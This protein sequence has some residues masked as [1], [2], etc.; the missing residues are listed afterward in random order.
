MVQPA[1]NYTP[2]TP[3]SFL[4]R[5]A[6]VFPEK[7]AVVYKDTRYTYRQLR[8]RVNRCATALQAAGVTPGDRVAFLC[9][10]IPP[11]LEAH[12]SVPLAGGVL[13]PINTRL[14]SSEIAYILHHSGAKVLCVD[15]ELADLIRPMRAQ[16]P[17][18]ETIINVIDGE[19]G[20]GLEGPDYETFLA[21]GTDELL[22]TWGV[23]AVGA[24][25]VCLRRLDP[26][27]VFRLIEDESVS[28][29]C[30]AP[31]V[32]IMLMSHPQ[33]KTAVFPRKLHVTTAGAPPSPTVIANMEALGAEI[34][35]VY[36]LTETYG[37][38]SIC[39]W[40]E[41]W[42]ALPADER[43]RKKA[44][45]GVPYIIAEEMRVVDD[46]MQDV[47]ADAETLGEVIMR[48]NNV[49]RGYYNQ[50]EATA[51]AFR[52][53]WFHSG[54]LAVMHPDGYV[55]LRDRKKDIIISG[56]ENIST[57]EVE[58]TIYRHPAVQEVAVVAIPDERWGEVPK[59]FVVPKPGMQ[60]T[61]ED[62][63][64]FCRQH[65]AHFKCPKAVEFGDLPKTSTGKIKKFELRE[66]EWQ[67]YEKR[68]H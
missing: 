67:G 59:A 2:L 20:E 63:I 45:Q 33:A 47:P 61:A 10:N 58:N 55:E 18:L 32:L 48:G 34:F 54:D 50:P 24:T 15:T 41:E 38:H 8:Q 14:S 68:I 13:V 64:A 62:I 30:G 9:P 23:T 57:I 28:H 53:G 66:K 11:M 37:P 5:S 26:A 39:A 42:E 1:V 51:E 52:G 35:H 27:E 4:A 43:A 46:A 22:F 56:G 44:R 60:P 49:M 12:Y 21:S 29:M 65:M 31:T 25:H 16:L 3:L 19:Y 17:Q 36:G 40:H 7:T 6:Y